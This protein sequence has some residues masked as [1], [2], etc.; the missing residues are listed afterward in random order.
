[1]FVADKSPAIDLGR[2]V[3]AHYPANAPAYGALTHIK[4][5]KLCFYCFG[6]AAAHGEANALGELKFEAW[7]HGPV[8]RDLWS[9]LRDTGSRPIETGHVLQAVPKKYPAEVEEHL[10]DA[11]T[12]YGLLSPWSLRQQSHLEAPWVEANASRNKV[13]ER[14]RI[15]AHFK[16]VWISDLVH[17]P[18]Y[19]TDAGSFY[20]DGIP[21]GGFR[22]LAEFATTLRAVLAR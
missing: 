9:R 21:S 1:M 3:L 7:E 2:W 12:V 15:A 20:L 18:A 10:T 17:L 11:L 16:Q 13:I 19:L 4:L 6:A 14:E 8:L 5:Q 22:S